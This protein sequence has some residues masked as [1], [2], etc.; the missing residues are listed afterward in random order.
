MTRINVVSP[1]ELHDKHLLAEYRELPRIFGLVRMAIARGEKF[2][3]PRNPEEYV[4][5]P[6]HVRFFYNKCGFLF[7]RQKSL[8]AEM[9]S[10]G[11]QVNYWPD[12]SLLYGISALW[13]QDWIPSVDAIELN[14]QRLSERMPK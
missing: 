14:S 13:L 2:D 6:G 10:R 4:L 5:G 12:E 1:S 3:D 8:C 7:L 11:F 9:H